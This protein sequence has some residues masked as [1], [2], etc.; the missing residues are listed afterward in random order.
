[1]SRASYG[2]MDASINGK[3]YTLKVSMSAVDKIL[4]R[5]GGIVDALEASGKM[6]PETLAAIIAAGAGLGQSSIPDLKD[7]ILQHGILKVTPIVVEYL[8]LV[9]DPSGKD[10]DED[11]EG[12]G[13][14]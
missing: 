9:L 8:G 7:D 13:E 10:K 12:S 5:F 14:D 1:M 2:V 11:D 6:N 4:K 3:D